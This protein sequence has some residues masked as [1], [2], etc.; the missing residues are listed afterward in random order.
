M[1]IADNIM[2]IRAKIAEYAI[3]SGRSAD[4]VRL[5]AVSKTFPA[6][7]IA[8]ARETANQFMFGENRVQEL[9]EKAPVL[10]DDIQWHIIGHLQSNK[11]AKAAELAH[12]VHSV[13]SEKLLNKLQAG[14]EVA[15][16]TLNILLEVNWTGE[17]SKSG[18]R[19]ADEALRLA[20]RTV[21]CK[22]LSLRGLMTM[23]EFDAT[24]ARLRETFSGVRELR[25]RMEREL[26]LTLPELSMGMSGDFRE[27]ILE[28]ATIVRIG[29]AIFGRR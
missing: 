28:G 14:A 7:D 22:N 9:A 27:A 20:E 17:E 26:G 13:D 8:E 11:A 19:G 10:P 12:W 25:D 15:N 18:I 16:R 3:A 4:A 24:E 2:Q 5:L 1:S 21:S 6:A 23:A 29:T